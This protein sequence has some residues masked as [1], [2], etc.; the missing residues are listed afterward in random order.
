MGPT[1]EAY[2]VETDLFP[3]EAL[4]VYSAYN[5]DDQILEEDRSKY[6]SAHRGGSQGDYR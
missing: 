4:Q 2:T 6:F 1:S 5:L 3:V